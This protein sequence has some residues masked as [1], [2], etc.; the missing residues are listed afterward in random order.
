[1]KVRNSAADNG[2]LIANI[3]RRLEPWQVGLSW[4]LRP[5][6]VI[7][8]RNCAIF[9]GRAHVQRITR[10]RQPIVSERGYSISTLPCPTSAASIMRTRGS[11]MASH[12]GATCR[13][14]V[15]LI[16]A[17]VPHGKVIERNVISRELL[18]RIPRSLGRL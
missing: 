10:H 18:S 13:L 8:Q 9:R 1:M 5:T 17:H 3:R 11:G 4:L 2:G 16:E 12:V 15:V 14:T 7:S 6:S